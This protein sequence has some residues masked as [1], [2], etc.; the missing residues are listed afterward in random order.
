MSLQPDPNPSTLNQSPTVVD[1]DGRYIAVEPPAVVP[2]QR[3]V[4]TEPGVHQPAVHQRV[5]TSTGRRFAFDSVIVGIAGVALTIIGLLAITRGGFDGAMEE[6]VVDVIGF[7]HTTTL[8]LIEI[9]IGLGLLI[10]AAARSR[11]AATFFG[12]ALG[13]GGFVGA[14]QT[15]S[16]RRSLALQSGLAWLAVITGAVIVLVSLL[17]P[18]MARTS[19]RVES[20]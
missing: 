13:V 10:S 12:L 15:D 17:M 6:P 5:A 8:G 19:T 18:R 4:M 3:V 14:V 1:G 20:D 7:T 2:V 16:F 9:G 11:S